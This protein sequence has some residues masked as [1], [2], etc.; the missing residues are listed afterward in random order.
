MKLDVK[1]LCGKLGKVAEEEVVST[2]DCNEYLLNKILRPLMREEK[3]LLK[4]VD[5]DQFDV[6]DIRQISAYYESLEMQGQKLEQ[7]VGAITNIEP[8]AC[9]ARQFC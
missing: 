8:V 7:F 6:E 1:G 4:D 3:V 9:M 2:R 5:F